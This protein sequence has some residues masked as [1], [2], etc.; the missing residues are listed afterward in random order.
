MYHLS[1][2]DPVPR[3]HL[4][5][6]FSSPQIWHHFLGPGGL[7]SGKQLNSKAS[8]CGQRQCRHQADYLRG[9]CAEMAWFFPWQ[10]FLPFDLGWE[11]V[12][13][14]P[15]LGW[16]GV[17]SLLPRFFQSVYNLKPPLHMYPA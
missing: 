8:E 15:T 4:S 7:A 17:L 1:T 2:G 10:A 14:G 5:S 11:R 12:L 9:K 6:L 3:P 16:Q 13:A